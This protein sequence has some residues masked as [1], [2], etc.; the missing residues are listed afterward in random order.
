MK[1]L[2]KAGQSIRDVA[3]TFGVHYTTLYRLLRSDTKMTP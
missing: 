2:L 3:S 1:R